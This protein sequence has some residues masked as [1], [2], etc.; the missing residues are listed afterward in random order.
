MIAILCQW[1]VNSNL[2]KSIGR[3][4]VEAEYG[5][6]PNLQIV[7]DI[8]ALSI[9]FPSS[10]RPYKDWTSVSSFKFE[11]SNQSFGEII[12]I[13]QSFLFLRI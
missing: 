4:G 7:E 10:I 6:S 9:Q 12:I 5:F 8:K 1:V 13:M 2:K 11:S 3:R